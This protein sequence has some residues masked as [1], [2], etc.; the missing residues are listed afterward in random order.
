VKSIISEINSFTASEA[1]LEQHL[2]KPDL[3][4]VVAKVEQM[5][6]EPPEIS[7][8]KKIG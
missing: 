7:L 1:L 2:Q 6:A 5:V 3:R 4:A 8:W